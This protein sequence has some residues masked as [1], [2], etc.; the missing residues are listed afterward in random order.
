MS[1]TRIYWLHCLSPTH[2]GTGRG[3]GYID[4]PI[5]RDKVTHWPVIPASAFKGVWTD[6]YE[7]L[8]DKDGAPTADDRPRRER[9]S[10]ELKMAFGF[11]PNDDTKA[12]NAGALIPTDARIVCLPVRSFQGTFAWCTSALALK[13]LRRDLELAGERDIPP[14]LVGPESSKVFCDSEE[15]LLREGE[16]T[17]LEDLDFDVEHNEVAKSWAHWISKQV[18]PNDSTWQTE[19]RRRFAIL[20][21]VVFDFLT[22]TGTEVTARVRIDDQTKTVVGSALW[23]EESLPAET[24]LAG[25]ITCDRIYEKSP[26]D[27]T[28]DGLLTKFAHKP[29]TLQVGG[30]ATVGRGR[31][32]CVFTP[33]N[34]GAR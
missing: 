15:T 9:L 26:G 22:E 8:E 24:I 4:L 34:G 20:P 30:K 10:H 16:K 32:R 7:H 6:H 23:N 27:I 25:L 17:Y 21:D 5:H 18:F 19:F 14:A 3:V 31:V 29:L 2:V 33:V 11:A 28:Q 1:M 13:M 12:S